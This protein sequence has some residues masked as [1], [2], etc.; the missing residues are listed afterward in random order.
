MTL[1]RIDEPIVEAMMNDPAPSIANIINNLIQ[2]GALVPVEPLDTNDAER[3]DIDGPW[4]EVGDIF[5][6]SEQRDK[7]RV[8]VF[9]V[10][11]GGNNEEV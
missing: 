5:L 11:I 2:V 8:A 9:D 3:V 4:F 7:F 10:G 1:Y 6:P